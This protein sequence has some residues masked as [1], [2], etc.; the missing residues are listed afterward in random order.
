VLGWLLA[1]LGFAFRISNFGSCNV[2]YSGIGVVIVLL[3]C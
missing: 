2:M 3:T 1:S